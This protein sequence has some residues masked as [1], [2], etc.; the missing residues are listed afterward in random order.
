MKK[1]CF[2]LADGDT[3]RTRGSFSV[4]ITEGRVQVES[5]M[6]KKGSSFNLA[7]SRMSQGEHLVS[8]SIIDMPGN[9]WMPVTA[10]RKPLTSD[11]VT[12]EIAFGGRSTCK[13]SVAGYYK[14]MRGIYEYFGSPR[15]IPPV[16]A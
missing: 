10:K 11:I 13:F 14:W 3:T 9:Y 12:A 4:G 5:P 16:D 15:F 1:L 6:K 2:P 8:S 7:Y